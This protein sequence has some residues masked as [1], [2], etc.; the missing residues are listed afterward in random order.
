MDKIEKPSDSEFYAP[1]SEPFRFCEYK[2]SPLSQPAR[3]WEHT[4]A[5]PALCVPRRKRRRRNLI[6]GWKPS[7]IYASRHATPYGPSTTSEAD[8][9]FISEHAN[10]RQTDSDYSKYPSSY[11][12]DIFFSLSFISKIP[13]RLR[14][15]FRRMKFLFR[16]IYFQQ[17][18]QPPLS[19][20]TSGLLLLFFR[21]KTDYVFIPGTV[22]V[23]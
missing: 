20:N 6:L 14:C 23:L 7:F 5:Y 9:I 21:Q 13:S 3:T 10:S 12:A 15:L 16:A 4:V 11:L 18:L 17:H 19:V 1:S 2:D 22:L 8:D